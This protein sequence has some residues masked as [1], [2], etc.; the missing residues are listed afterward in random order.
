M[1]WIAVAAVLVFFLVSYRKP[2]LVPTKA[3]WIAESIYG[4]GRN[5]IA[6]DVIGP[7]HS[8][9]SPKIPEAWP[10]VT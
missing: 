1:V 4:F 2:K 3:Q 5:G 10:S 7:T 8:H 9:V 6:S